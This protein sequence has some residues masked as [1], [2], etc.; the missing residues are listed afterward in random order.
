[1]IKL[2]A[3]LSGLAYLLALSSVVA[4]AVLMLTAEGPDGLSEGPACCERSVLPSVS[5]RC[6]TACAV[7]TA[8]NPILQMRKLRYSLSTLLTTLS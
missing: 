7:V 6:L 2:L 8:S 4:C 5:N 1:M 3:C